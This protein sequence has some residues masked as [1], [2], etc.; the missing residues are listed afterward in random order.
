MAKRDSMRFMNR[1]FVKIAGRRWRNQSLLMHVGRKSG[2]EYRNPVAAYP[3]NDGFVIPIMFGPAS[4]WVQ[5]I[6]AADCFTL[7]TKGRDVLLGSAEILPFEE[8]R[9]AFPGWLQ[10]AIR[11]GKRDQFVWARRVADQS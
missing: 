3:L 4:N 2:R 5:N 7:R 8:V 6:M 10:V 9:G 1:M 11:M